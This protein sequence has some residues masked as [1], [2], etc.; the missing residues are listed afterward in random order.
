[1]TADTEDNPSPQKQREGTQNF[2]KREPGEVSICAKIDEV[3]WLSFISFGWVFSYLWRTYRGKSEPCT[4]W[5]CSIFDSANVNMSRLEVMWNEERKRSPEHPS[6]FRV[7]MRFI[8][9]R[10]IGACFIFALC[11]I[12][13]FIGPTCLVRGLIAYVEDPPLED[14]GGINYIYGLYIVMAILL[15]EIS[16]V[17]L[18]GACWAVSYRTGIRVRGAVLSLMYKHLMNSKSLRNKTP[19]EIVNVCANDGQRLFDAITFAPLVLIGPFVLVGGLIY[20][21]KVI[22]WPSLSGILVFFIFD[23]VQ[24]ILGITMVKFRNRAI[25]K[26]EKRMNLMGEIIRSIRT[27]KMNSWEDIFIK[28]VTDMRKNEKNCLKVAG[29][30]QSLAIATGTIVPVVATIVTVLVVVATGS[31]LKASDA[32]SSITVFFVMLFGIRMIPYG[33]RYLA[34]ASQSIRKIQEMLNY[35]T[36]DQQIPHP[37]NYDIAIQ[38]KGAKFVWDTVEEEKPKEDAKKN[39]KVPNGENGKIPSEDNAE[40]SVPLTAENPI[41]KSDFSLNDINLII[42]KKELIGVCGGVGSGKT[43]LLHAIVG[44]LQY[45]SGDFAISGNPVLVSQV[46]CILNATVREN[47]LF[48]LPFNSQRYY[49]AINCSELTHD[50]ESMPKNEQT[51][52]GER[53]TTLSGGQRARISLARA[54]YSMRDIYL[55]DDIFSSID[56]QVADKIFSRAIKEYLESKTVLL[57]TSDAEFLSKCDKIVFMQDGKIQG[58]DTH[59]ALLESSPEYKDFSSIIFNQPVTILEL[60]LQKFRSPRKIMKMKTR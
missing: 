50:L 25:D 52:I 35:P 16:R 40:E 10:L 24:A 43:S 56:K 13:G 54:L 1:M 4:N 27:I 34:E 12:F 57:V 6:L 33:S 37:K 59:D 36:F 22:G 49:R 21:L 46:P 2:I 18:Y 60:I 51:E 19:A 8:K 41:G 20:L 53:G 17:L 44:Q 11:L 48:G 32:F 14:D 42:Q 26:T 47:I 5:T 30:A 15:V 9:Y 45:E 29:Y 39:G 28:R 55:L 31:D 7:I 38:M 3:G 58:F 23:V